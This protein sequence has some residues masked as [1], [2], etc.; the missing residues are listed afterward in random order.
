MVHRG[1][2]IYQSVGSLGVLEEILREFGTHNGWRL[3]FFERVRRPSLLHGVVDG[4]DVDVGCVERVRGLVQNV[5]G[6]MCFVASVV[7][8]NKYY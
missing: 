1:V 2:S 3:A 5:D 4:I 8:H 7:V 6:D